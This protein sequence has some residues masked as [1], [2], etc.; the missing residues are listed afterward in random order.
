MIRRFYSL[1]LF[2]MI[3]GTILAQSSINVQDISNPNEI[4][5]NSGDSALVR[6]RGNTTGLLFYQ[7]SSK[8]QSLIPSRTE[9][10]LSGECIYDFIFPSGIN[11]RDQTLFIDYLP[12]GSYTIDTNLEPKQVKTYQVKVTH[13]FYPI[14]RRKAL[15]ELQKG[16]FDEALEEL[17][18][19]NNC[20]DKDTIDIKKIRNEVVEYKKLRR[21]A[22]EAFENQ[23]YYTATMKYRNLW[24][25]CPSDTLSKKRY[26]ESQYMLA[27]ECDSLYDNA[28]D[29]YKELTTFTKNRSK[30]KIN[31]N[32]AVRLFDTVIM[33]A[34]QL[35]NENNKEKFISDAT[36]WIE[37]IE[38]KGETPFIF[39]NS[40][41]Y[42]Y[43]KD[44]PIGFSYSSLAEGTGGFIQID[45]NTML[46]EEIRSTCRYGDTKF[47]EINI[48][49]GG[50]RRLFNF[51]W[52]HYGPGFTLKFYHGRYQGGIYP[53]IGYGESEL[54]DTHYMGED[55]SLP[56]NEIPEKYEDGWKKKNAAFAISPIV[57]IDIKIQFVVLRLSYQ[58]R[59]AT[60]SKLGDFIG[61][62]RF[63]FGAGIAF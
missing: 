7:D 42:E 22:D 41:T 12:D 5:P 27:Y 49:F 15:E 28:V 18:L 24:H 1:L 51:L 2:G 58:Y 16:N 44:T 59:I 43:N 10:V 55:V 57:G 11:Y 6:V 13:P 21:E 56:K 53:K 20:L 17:K 62:S 52:I 19:A 26:N 36:T 40:L 39:K 34:N 31:I 35:D 46:F 47:A 37:K 50:T 3:V 14:H 60:E 30:N 38:E 33:K 45:L 61:R 32:E 48:A 4:F 29:Y 63:S 54:L 25:N 8:S 23:M 9:T